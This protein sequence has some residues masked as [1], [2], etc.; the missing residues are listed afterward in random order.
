MHAIRCIIPFFKPNK[1]H[2][3]LLGTTADQAQFIVRSLPAHQCSFLRD[4]NELPDNTDIQLLIV[5][6][7]ASA[8]TTEALAWAH[9]H[10]LPVLLLAT[11]ADQS[12]LLSALATGTCDYVLTPLRKADLTTRVNLLLKRCYADFEDTQAHRFGDFV[13]EM[14]GYRVRY[15]EEDIILTQKEFALALLLLNHLG[16]P[17][18]RA[19]IQESI[20][21]TQ[22]AIPTRTIDTHTSRVRSKLGLQPARGYQLAPVYGFGYQLTRIPA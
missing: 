12:L 17:L 14:P 5:A 4:H 22:E 7:S 2:I 1:M 18:S 15:Q 8:H 11:P 10:Q 6:V 3:A 9:A 19:Y 21:G 13:F 20:W 16:H